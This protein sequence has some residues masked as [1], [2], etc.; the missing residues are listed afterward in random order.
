VPETAAEPH[1]ITLTLPYPV[2]ANRYWKQFVMGKRV[3]QGPSHDATKYK[4]EV[5]QAAVLQRIGQ[6][7]KGRVRVEIELYPHRPLDW[8]KRA[9]RDPETWDDTVQCLD[10]DNANKVLLDALKG[11]AID[12]DKWVRELH[13]RRMEPVGD[14]HVVVRI[15]PLTV[16][17]AQADLLEAAAA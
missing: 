5:A 7:I 1:V 16:V 4:R 2:S 6:P 10:L 3:M 15:A 17:R 13:S 11:V 12:D 9:A 14:A 8:K